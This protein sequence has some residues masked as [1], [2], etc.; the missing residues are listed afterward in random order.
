MVGTTTEPRSQ[1]AINGAKGATARATWPFGGDHIQAVTTSLPADQREALRWFFHYCVE[2]E[3]SMADAARQLRYGKGGQ[4]SYDK[5]TVWK[6]YTFGKKYEGSLTNFVKAVN[7]FRRAC[8]EREDISEV[9][10]VKTATAENIWNYCRLAFKYKTFTFIYGD[11]QIGKTWALQKFQRDNN[12]GR[13]RYVRLSASGG[14]QLMMKE[15][16]KACALKAD[17][18]FEKLRFRVF[19]ATDENTLW[20]FDEIHQTFVSYHKRAR[21]SC[22]EVIRELHDRTGCGI[23]LS[24]TNTAR[25]EIEAGDH[26]KLLEQ[27]NRR[28]IFKLQLPKYATKADINAIARHFGLPAATGEAEALVKE[29]IRGSGLKAYTTFLQAAGELAKN[30]RQRLKWDHFVHAHDMIAKLSA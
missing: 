30:K 6:V 29:V 28:G 21:L 12:H 5:S 8:A 22:L 20:I 24:G 18:P 23:V 14:T 26:A 15:C 13:T 1:A 4:K 16:A 9:V 7:S 3:I 27:L 17:A 10:F 19:N 25:E 2:T 11:S